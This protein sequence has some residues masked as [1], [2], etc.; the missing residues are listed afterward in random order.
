[1]TYFQVTGFVTFGRGRTQPS[2]CS[3]VWQNG[4]AGLAVLL[5]LIADGT[6]TTFVA[7]RRLQAVDA[8]RAGIGW[9]N[10]LREPLQLGSVLGRQDP[11]LGRGAGFAGV[12]AQL[13]AEAARSCAGCG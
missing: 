8:A 11:P 10:M 5:E 13:N 3:S 7:D 9:D 2:P 1:V 6:G 12:R 4:D